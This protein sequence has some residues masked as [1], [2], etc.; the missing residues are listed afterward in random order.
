MEN[1]LQNCVVIEDENSDDTTMVRLGSRITVLDKEFNEEV[2][3]EVVGSQ[4]ADPMNGRISEDSPFGR[5]LL[6]KSVGNEVEVE[7][8]AG[9]LYY[10][11]LNIEK[12]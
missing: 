10:Q 7:A 12:A 6:G 11:I 4:E 1:I 5:A 2:V 9:T 3:Y 8:P